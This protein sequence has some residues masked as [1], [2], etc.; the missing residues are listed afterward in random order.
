[1]V[2][3]H[4]LRGVSRG[5]KSQKTAFSFLDPYTQRVKRPEKSTL[6]VGRAP[7]LLRSLPVNRGASSTIGTEIINTEYN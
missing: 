1:M 5:F 3:I 4:D 7:E 2:R 6:M